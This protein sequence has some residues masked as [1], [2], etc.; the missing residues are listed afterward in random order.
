[1]ADLHTNSEPLMNEQRPRAI[2]DMATI[3]D[4]DLGHIARIPGRHLDSELEEPALQ[5]I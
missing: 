1:M 5:R 3:G 2:D 4:M